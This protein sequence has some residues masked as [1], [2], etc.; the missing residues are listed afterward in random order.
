M[1]SQKKITGLVL[2]SALIFSLCVSS[3]YA[4]EK[5]VVS[6]LSGLAAQAGA[7]AES[8]SLGEMININSATPE[9]LA[10]IPG[11][12]S[13]LSEAIVNYRQANGAFTGIKDLLNVE[14]IDMNLLEKIKPLLKF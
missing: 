11:I 8:G 9:L 6:A 5:N 1:V 14:G 2:S 13:Q 10:A 12:G 7:L 4:E 3:V